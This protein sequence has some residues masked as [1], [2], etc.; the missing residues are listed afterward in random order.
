MLHSGRCIRPAG[1]FQDRLDARHQFARGKGFGHIIIGAQFQSDDAVDLIIACG[2]KQDRHLGHGP[3]AAADL[4]A[5]HFR[6]THIQHDQVG[7]FARGMHQGA[8]AI[9]GGEDSVACP[10][11]CQRHQVAQARVV[12]DKQDLHASGPVVLALET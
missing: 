5:V 7:L 1:P 2:Q 9:A 4:K 12:I 3:D 6:Q 8:L 10:L 11:Q